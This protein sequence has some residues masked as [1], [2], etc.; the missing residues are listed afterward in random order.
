MQDTW[1][2]GV[3]TAPNI[4]TNPETYEIENRALDPEQK[5]ITTLQDCA[6]WS[7]KLAVDLGAGTSFWVPHLAHTARHV[8]SI[9]PDPNLR[10]L[11]MQ[12]LV[13]QRI[14]N[15]SILA[16][17]AEQTMLADHSVD[18]VHARFAYF[19]G[20]G[21]EAGIKELE[22]IITPGGSACII[23]NDLEEG[24]FAHWLKQLPSNYQRNPDTLHAFWTSHGFTEHTVRSCW[25][26][27]QRQDLEDVVRLEFA[28]AADQI[29]ASHSGTTVDYSFKIYHRTF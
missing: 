12:R 5:L 3:H 15:A 2:K 20:P 28:D 21:C 26:F 19:W 27:E 9:E 6:D 14:L 24:T 11:G 17:S 16:G 22:R 29:I 4:Q 8:F 7:G 25:Q 18:V 1:L 10:I 13:E 23:D